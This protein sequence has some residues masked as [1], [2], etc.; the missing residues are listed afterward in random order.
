VDGVPLGHPTYN[1]YRSD[2]ATLLPGYANS[3]AAVGLFVLDRHHPHEWPAH[4]R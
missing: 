1:L 3:N 4:H 2:I